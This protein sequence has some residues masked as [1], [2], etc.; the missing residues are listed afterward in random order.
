MRQAR[1]QVC[2][3]LSHPSE[4][5]T[6]TDLFDKMQSAIAI[7][8]SRTALM[9]FNHP[10]LAKPFIKSSMDDPPP[11]TAVTVLTN[12]FKLFLI[13]WM[14]SMPYCSTW[15]EKTVHHQIA[16]LP[17]NTSVITILKTN[18]KR[19]VDVFVVFVALI[20]LAPG[21]V[22]HSIHSRS[23]IYNMYV[24]STSFFALVHASSDYYASWRGSS[25]ALNIAL[26]MGASKS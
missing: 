5:C 14:F 6:I 4:Q 2:D 7:L 3:V 17:L 9:C 15:Q 18:L 26:V 13:L 23:S 22:C 11:G 1:E 20:A 8:T 24:W 25:Q 19:E 16:F 10:L 21:L 12:S